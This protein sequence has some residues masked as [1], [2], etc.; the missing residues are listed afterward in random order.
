MRKPCELYIHGWGRECSN[1]WRIKYSWELT[2][3]DIH[4]FPTT[5]IFYLIYG[6]SSLILRMYIKQYSDTC[7]LTAP[8]TIIFRRPSDGT[9]VFNTYIE[10]Y[11]CAIQRFR[12]YIAPNARFNVNSLMSNVS[13]RTGMNFG[14]RVHRFWHANSVQ[15]QSLLRNSGHS[16]PEFKDACYKLHN[17]CIICT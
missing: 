6:I 13:T 12:L 7:N 2:V 17:E 11:R 15:I 1:A 14:K 3:M 10:P 8:R 4:G 5:I 9:L 16:S